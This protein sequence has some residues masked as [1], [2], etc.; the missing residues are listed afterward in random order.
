MREVYQPELLDLLASFPSRPYEG[1]AW[2]ITFDGQPLTRANTRGARWNPRDVRA[3][4][5][6]L[7]VECARAEFQHV[8]GL[9]PTRPTKSRVQ[10]HWA[11]A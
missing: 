9:Q 8:L 2:R 3:L 6:S 10:Y 11:E 7:A 4:Y 1:Q 5:T